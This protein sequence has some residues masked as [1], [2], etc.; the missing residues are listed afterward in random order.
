MKH[1]SYEIV[2]FGVIP[3]WDKERVTT[4]QN[5][6]SVGDKV[7]KDVVGSNLLTVVAIEHYPTISVLYV[8]ES[9]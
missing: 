8:E 4:F 6:V 1:F 2:P 9:K 5:P 7:K 3:A